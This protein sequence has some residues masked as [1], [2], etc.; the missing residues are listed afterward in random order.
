[1]QDKIAVTKTVN[2]SFEILA[3]SIFG[4]NSKIAFK[5]K[6]RGMKSGECSD[7]SG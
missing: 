3:N 4:N 2:E 1:M 7:N 5:K 6:L